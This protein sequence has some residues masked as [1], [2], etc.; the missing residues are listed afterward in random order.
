MQPNNIPYPRRTLIRKILRQLARC[1]LIIGFNIKVSGKAN[2][3]KTGPFIVAGNHNSALDPTL[4]LFVIPHQIEFLGSGDLPIDPRMSMFTTLYGFIPINRG[5]VDQVGLSQALSILQQNGI[6]GIFPEGGI[7]DK[8]LKQPKTGISYLAFKSKT[9]II[10]IGITGFRNGIKDFNP[11][12]RIIIHISIGERIQTQGIYN[13]QL[14][15]KEN[16]VS[17]AEI[18]MKRIESLMV[19]DN[20]DDFETKIN[21][22]LEYIITPIQGDKTKLHFND[23]SH[24]TFLIEHPVIMDT[25]IRNLKLPIKALMI[26]NSEINADYFTNALKIL[27]RFLQ[28][29]HGFLPYRFGTENSIKTMSVIN[30]FLSTL[31]KELPFIRS[32]EIR[33]KQI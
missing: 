5:Y 20:R 8:K 18:V 19:K 31:E 12:R 26:R 7:W 23:L 14:S 30:D 1:L 6:L 28:E 13:D 16:M 11:F 29:N 27:Q 4:L 33:E 21:N 3:P 24:L 32:I 17:A 9:D 25:F 15:M 10:P 2:L 22:N